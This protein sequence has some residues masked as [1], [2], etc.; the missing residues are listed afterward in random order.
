MIELEVLIVFVF[1]S[2]KILVIKYFLF[3]EVVDKFY[4]DK[5]YYFGLFEEVDEEIFCVFVEMF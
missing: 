1:Y 4:F 5:F 2:D 3:C